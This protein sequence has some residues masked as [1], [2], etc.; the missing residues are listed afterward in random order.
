ML[1]IKEILYKIAK[2]KFIKSF[3]GL[4]YQNKNQKEKSNTIARH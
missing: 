2:M 4:T 1:N 3:P